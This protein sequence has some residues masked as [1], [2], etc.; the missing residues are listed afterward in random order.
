[1][2]R[3]LVEGERLLRALGQSAF[4]TEIASI[5][6]LPHQR[7]AVHDHAEALGCATCC[8][9]CGGGKTIMTGLYIREMISRRLLKRILIVP[10]AGLVGNWQREF[11]VLFSLH[12]DIVSGSDARTNNPS[13]DIE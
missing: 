7:I 4:A 11:S 10:P 9:R 2:V 13:R 8:R 6:P 1:V 12:F 5:D 3:A